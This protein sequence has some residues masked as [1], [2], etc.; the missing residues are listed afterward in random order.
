LLR[1]NEEFARARHFDHHLSF[2]IV[3]IDHFKRINDRWGHA[4]GDEVLRTLCKVWRAV[5]RQGDLLARVGGEE[6]AWLLTETDL[7]RSHLTA[8]KLR[9]LAADQ[10]VTW[11]HDTIRF[12]V[13][14]GAW[15][16]ITTDGSVE[17]PIHRADAALYQ[18]KKNTRNRT[19]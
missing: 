13:S 2:V 16:L 12:T 1:A 5:I 9:Q 18:A 19:E 10:T 14:A 8:E 15:T 4:A 7:K 11:N 6:F 17:D 3:D